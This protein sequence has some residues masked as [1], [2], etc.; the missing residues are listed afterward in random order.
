[1]KNLITELLEKDFKLV[2]ATTGGGAEMISELTRHGGSSAFFQNG[3]VPWNENALKT[4]INGKP[5]KYCSPTTACAMAV[6]AFHQSRGIEESVKN[7]GI[8]ITCKLGLN[9]DERKGREHAIYVA[10]QTAHTTTT[11]S[12]VLTEKRTREEES[13]LASDIGILAL[14][15]AVG[16]DTR[17]YM[18]MIDEKIESVNAMVSLGVVDVFVGKNPKYFT[19]SNF[20]ASDN[21]PQV[22]LSSSLNPLTKN[23]LEMARVA[24]EITKQRIW[25]EMSIKNADK[26]PIDYIEYKKRI[27]IANQRIADANASYI[28]GIII[29]NAGTFTEKSQILPATFVIGADTYNRLPD[30]KFYGGH[31]QMLRALDEVKRNG[32]RFL[33]F[34]RKGIEIRHDSATLKER[35]A[36]V[37]DTKYMDDGHSSSKERQS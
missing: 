29:T 12:V 35:S 3:V 24:A 5:D 36:F 27:K 1:M 18:P 28:A 20:S 17:P 14:Y 16:L 19:V 30:P 31:E 10:C 11:Y 32:I 15:E 21:N 9:S 4:F 34:E 2:V 8:G 37:D 7:I 33:V 22:I 25:L 26:P 23:H 6:A 13:E